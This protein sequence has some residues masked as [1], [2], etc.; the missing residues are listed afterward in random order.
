MANEDYWKFAESEHH[1]NSTQADI[2]KHA[3]TW[4]L[5]AFGAIA[6][7]LKSSG[8]LLWV[9]SPAI[10]VCTVSA[11]A[12]IG[13]LVLWINDQ[14]VYQRL[15]D[16]GFIIALR[17][18][19]DNPE[20][21]PIRWMMMYAAEGKGMARWM[22][23]FYTI[24]MW[25]LLVISI[26]ATLLRDEIQALSQG[27]EGGY[28]AIIMVLLCVTQGVAVLWVQL[29]KKEVG[30]RNRAALFGDREFEMLFVGDEA[31]RSRIAHVIGRYTPR[32]T[33][34][35]MEQEG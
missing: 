25:G 10:L 5:A 9:V 23:H 14:L 22:T 24:P 1:F 17:M 21:P 6:I 19:Y 26:T 28:G 7:L 35:A 18:E 8:D 3:A 12:T 16:C 20:L 11:M 2:R 15:L 27:V 30:A 34:I 4:M 13:L 33:P 32:T 31:A 29:K